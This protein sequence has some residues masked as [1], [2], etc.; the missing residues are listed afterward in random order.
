MLPAVAVLY[1]GFR[2]NWNERDVGLVLAAVGVCAMAVQGG[3]VRPVVA[4][5]GERAALLS[6]LGAG[7][8]G[9]AI[10]GFAST[11]AMFL[12]GVPVMALWGFAQPSMT[13]LM[14]ERVDADE[15]GK[16]Q[17]AAASLM[18]LSGL[19][20]PWIFALS[21]AYAIDPAKGLMV[22]GVPFYLASS[23]LVVAFFIGV[24]VARK[25]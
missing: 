9:F 1:M 3:M 6:G 10:Y 15:Q 21:F 20:G 25:S 16:L 23:A 13:A 11:G 12:I 7:A 2:Y 24:G 14:S 5:I 18:G 8:L 22:P 4:K 19:A 17:G